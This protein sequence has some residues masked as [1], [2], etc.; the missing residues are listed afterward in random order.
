MEVDEAGEEATEESESVP[1][2]EPP[3]E[4]ASG[5]DPQQEDA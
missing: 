5:E 2:P 4:D 3:P 1:I